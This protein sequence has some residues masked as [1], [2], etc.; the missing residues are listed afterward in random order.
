MRKKIYSKSVF[1]VCTM[2]IVL[3]GMTGCGAKKSETDQIKI[4]FSIDSL[5]IERWQKDVKL[6][7]EKANELGA[8]VILKNATEDNEI[9]RKQ[10]QELIESD[11]DVL[12]VIPYDKDGLTSLIKMAKKKDIKVIAYDRLIRNAN[13]DMYISFDNVEV[14]R[15][16]AQ[17]LLDKMDN[18]NYIIINGSTIDNNSFMFNEGYKLALD[19][20]LKDGSINILDEKWADDWREEVAYNCVNEAIKNNQNIDGIIAANDRLADGA[21]KALSENR[22]AGNVLVAGHDADLS[23]CQRIVEGTQLVTVYKPIK[24]LA[25]EA[26]RIAVSLAKGEVVSSD[27]TINDGSYEVPYKLFQ[28][29]VITKENMQIIIDE[30]FHTEEQIYRN[31]KESQ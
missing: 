30:G 11:I 19:K 25:S 31:E 13:V 23:A 14:G 29:I 4:G 2:V 17:T 6:F 12:V 20:Y 28:P 15:L 7:E 5:V 16:M 26:A 8:E 9:Q 24:K 21:I 27:T 18:G 22:V 3:G 1:I 10:V